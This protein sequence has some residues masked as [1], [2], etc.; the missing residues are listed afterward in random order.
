[1]RR[2]EHLLHQRTDAKDESQT[3]PQELEA[4]SVG[5]CV[6]T[7]VHTQTHAL[8][9]IRNSTAE[10]VRGW[11]G[12]WVKGVKKK[13]ECGWPGLGTSHVPGTV[14]GAT[15]HWK[16]FMGRN[17][18]DSFRTVGKIWFKLFLGM[19]AAERWAKPGRGDW[20]WNREMLASKARQSKDRRPTKWWQA[21]ITVTS[22]DFQSTAFSLKSEWATVEAGKHEDV[23]THLQN[24][25]PDT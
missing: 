23:S 14:P 19:G 9:T 8:W 15:R 18:Q 7:H 22:L 17:T 5:E 2:S 25:P 1:M 20:A 13:E 6:R 21:V 10:C 3:C 16:Q 11:Q 12:T 24:F 4:W